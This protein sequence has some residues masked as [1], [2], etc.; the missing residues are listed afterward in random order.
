MFSLKQTCKFI[1]AGFI[2]LLLF[3]SCVTTEQT[4]YM[5]QAEVTG[6]ISQ[7]PIH[8]T[9]STDTPSVTFSPKL[10]YNTNTTLT[11]SVDESRGLYGAD[12]FYI[13]N[14]TSLIWDM[15]TM[16][17]GL[18]I[19][20]KVSRTFAISLGVN[21][22]SQPNF[23][24][25]GGTVG[26][27]LFS[28]KEGSA[29]RFDVGLNIQSMRYDVYTI[30]STVTT[31]FWGGTD[32]YTGFYWDTGKS[33]SINPYLNFTYN[34]AHKSWLVNFF[35]NAG[36]SIQTLFSFEPRTSIHAFGTYT[37][38]DLRGSTTAGFFNFTPG[39]YFFIGESN[40]ILLGSRFFLETQIEGADPTLFIL[41]M[42][43]FDFVL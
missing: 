31:G 32:E 5:Q 41:P 15:Q 34:S 4:L 17:A 23:N 12:T 8:L 37:R 30:V 38:T 40:R 19:D 24:A 28:Y 25:W 42:I 20:L 35:I 39:I 9:D 33:T 13:P 43:Q 21:Y 1:F 7:P 18:D 29:F 27:G 11:G 2:C 16:Y 36:Y 6:P 14:A 10:S 3:I 22:S 26:I